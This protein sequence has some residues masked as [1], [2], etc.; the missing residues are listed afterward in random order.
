MTK[1]KR[2]YLQ[3]L[4]DL[5]VDELFS[6]PEF[7]DTERIYYFTLDPKEEAIMQALIYTHSKV[8]F[9]L[10]LG[11]FKAKFR[12]FNFSITEVK[13][14]LLYVM[15]RYFAKEQIPVELP[16]RNMLAANNNRILGLM[17][18]N[19]STKIAVEILTDRMKVLTRNL[20][21]P[22][23]ILRELLLYFKQKRVIFPE[24]SV[25]QNI[26]GKEIVLEEKRL[27]S[28]INKRV[29][30]NI[31]KLLDNLLE[32]TDISE[33]IVSIKQHPKNFNFKQIQQ[34]VKKHKIYYPLYKFTKYFLPML[35]ISQENIK[36]YASLVHY[37]NKHRLQELPKHLSH[38]YLLCYAY[39]RFQLMNDHLIQTLYHYI[40]L[41]R[42]DAK[43][44]AE[45][46]V[47]EIYNNIYKHFKPAGYLLKMFLNPK[48]SRLAF[49]EIQK[50]AYK[51]LSKTKLKL[52]S[53]YLMEQCVDKTAY[54]W[55]YHADNGRCIINNLRHIFMVIDFECNKHNKPLLSGINFLKSIFNQNKNLNQVKFSEIPKQ[56]IP[57]K[58]RKYFRECSKRYRYSCCSKWRY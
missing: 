39:N 35:E 8:H 48:L 51:K 12:L 1:Q 44:Y 36:Y 54:E 5:E 42:A 52:V 28:I 46:K 7:I 58:L 40:D 49:K 9:I 29:P 27:Q 53:K 6:L 25:I 43:K 13:E 32:A 45:Q 22:E 57:E 34:E 26:I 50:K 38:L 31:V 17:D 30:A 18:Y 24:Y 2:K 37:Y 55:Q 56:V 14:D 4:S 21:K 10:Q 33:S 3:I 41:Y 47:V 11:Y 19:N 23:I 16:S 20:S 15:H